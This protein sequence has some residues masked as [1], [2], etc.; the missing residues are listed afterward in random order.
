LEQTVAKAKS[1]DKSKKGILDK[2]VKKVT[3]AVVTV[4]ALGRPAAELVH[5]SMPQNAKARRIDKRVAKKR[6]RYAARVK[7]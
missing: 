5:P 2:V 1:Q 3:K 4:K 6:A 7:A